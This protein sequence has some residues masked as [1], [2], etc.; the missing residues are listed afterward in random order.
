MTALGITVGF[1]LSGFITLVS[2][3]GIAFIILS[4]PVISHLFLVPKYIKETKGTDLSEVQI[5]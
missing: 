2:N 4:I 1:V 5:K 3:L